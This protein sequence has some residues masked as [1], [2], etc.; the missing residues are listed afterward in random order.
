[1]THTKFIQDRPHTWSYRNGYQHDGWPAY[2]ISEEELHTEEQLA[3]WLNH[4]GRKMWIIPADLEGLTA[5][6]RERNRG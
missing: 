6:Y 4:L 2:W 3:W 1:M 5:A